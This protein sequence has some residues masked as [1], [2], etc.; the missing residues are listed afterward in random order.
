MK[1]TVYPLLCFVKILLS[2]SSGAFFL[3]LKLVPSN[4]Q[5]LLTPKMRLF[6][7]H[8]LIEVEVV[9]ILTYETYLAVSSNS[10]RTVKAIVLF[11]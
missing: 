1:T 8:S 9:V 7:T 2:A 11:D 6:K 10:L 3:Y 4:V 5:Q